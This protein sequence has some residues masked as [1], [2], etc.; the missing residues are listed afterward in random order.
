LARIAGPSATA[1]E[2]PGKPKLLV[3]VREALRMR[4]Y[5]PRTEEAY[6]H[7]IRRYIFFHHLRHPAE[8]GAAGVRDYLSHLAVR[9]QVSA[10]TQNQAFAALLFLYRHVLGM[11]LG[12]LGD[13]IRAK[14]PRRLPVVL[15]LEEVERVFAHLDGVS[16]LICRLLYGSGMRLLECLGMRVKDLDFQRCEITVRDG[17]GRKDRVTMLPATC[18]ADLEDHLCGVRRQH[19]ADLRGGLG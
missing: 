2:A 12:P 1:A 6:V 3:R 18:A 13:V 10:S 17:K 7:W 15:T 8:L 14:R 4:Q 5:S 16:L 19:E 11:D 9:K